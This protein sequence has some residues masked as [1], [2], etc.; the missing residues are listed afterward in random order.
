MFARA[1]G[2]ANKEGFVQGYP[3]DK[4]SIGTRDIQQ[5]FSQTL[6]N[7]IFSQD[8]NLTL[9]TITTTH[10]R[11]NP[12]APFSIKNPRIKT[13]ISDDYATK[14]QQ[15]CQATG[16]GDQ[17]DHLV[18]LAA[19]QDGSSKA[20]CG[21]I[22]NS[23]NPASGRGAYG[24][25]RGPILDTQTK[26]TW[27]WNLQ[28]AKEKYHKEI[29]DKVAGCADIDSSMYQGRCG[30]NTKAGK[31]VP[32]Q[33]GQ[34]AYPYSPTLNCSANNLV[35]KGDSCPR[36]A[37]KI[38]LNE[39]G[40]PVQVQSPAAGPCTPLPNGSLSRD[41]LV[42]RAISAGCSDEGSLAYALKAG[43][44]TNY[45]DNL[46]QS[47]AFKA[48]QERA[49]I[50]IDTT[51]LKNGKI[52]AAKALD[53]FKRVNDH[54]LSTRDGALEFA[55]R[56]LCF[57]RGTLDSFDFCSELRPNTPP[58]FELDCLQ[59]AFLKAGGQKTGTMFP[60]DPSFWNAKASNWGD[61]G[62]I[63]QSVVNRLSSSNRAEQEA[64]TKEFYGITLQAKSDPSTPFDKIKFIRID[65]GNQ[66]LNFS[67][68]VGYDMKGVN[69]TMGRNV[70][71]SPS[72]NWGDDAAPAKAVDGNEQLRSFP[73]IYH[74][75]D[76]NYPFFQVELDNPMRL[77][78]IRIYN[79][80]DCCQERLGVFRI[81][82]LDVSGKTVWTNLLKGDP[83]QTFK[84]EETPANAPI[85]RFQDM[86][87]EIGCTRVFT[88]ADIPWDAW[89]RKQ[90]WDTVKRDMNAYKGLTDNCSGNNWQHEWCSPGKC[91]KK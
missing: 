63:I 16:N 87:S 6:P 89:W 66:A 70:S 35:T 52:T 7:V 58:P 32:I 8:K 15:E 46:A 51:S 85:S 2:Q 42:Q 28:E 68:I 29:C 77:S 39:D 90:N 44:D 81:S 49:V 22:Y 11:I 9:E 57:K 61:V 21:W 31:A 19:S 59:K 78:Y 10:N 34:V 83:I 25:I 12:G 76:A 64:A 1:F 67:Q 60:K 79:R 56:D 5:Y 71:A 4:G 62:K 53:E 26:G 82:A 75:K 73:D 41:C 91:P 50:G 54:A 86:Y 72:L 88:E 80:G 40:K 45:V 74:S 36:V 27:M 65:S 18:S 37:A 23:Q 69:V 47:T 43:S 33:N 38:V 48:Y 30:W 84:I 14:R 17:F 3:N 24:S 55:S 20:R 13:A